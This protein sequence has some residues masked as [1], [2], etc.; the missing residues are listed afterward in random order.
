[1]SGCSTGGDVR[2][3]S[4]AA[5]KVPANSRKSDL[6]L[7]VTNKCVPMNHCQAKLISFPELLNVSLRN[8][9]ADFFISQIESIVLALS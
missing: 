6:G 7:A 8:S 9:R 3:D 1:M 5:T 2:Q 4:P